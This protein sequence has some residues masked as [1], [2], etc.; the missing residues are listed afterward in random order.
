[1][2]TTIRWYAG[3]GSPEILPAASGGFNTLGFFGANFGFSIR[4]G[5]YNNSSFRTTADGSSNGGAL[6]NLR[7]AN[8]SGAYVAGELTATELKEIDNDEATLKIT[9]TTDSAIQTQN[10]VL[11]AFDRVDI[12]SNP[13]GVTILAAE[14]RND[15]TA[16]RGSGDTSWTSIA[17]SGST[18]GLEDQTTEDSTTHDFFIALTATPTSIGEK[19][20]VG[21]YWET[22]F[23]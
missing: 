23:L 5:E 19:T 10:S 1:M 11:R 3:D 2:A 8:S 17:G 21:F 16:G 20:S 15:I 14:I 7:W 12:N 6:P 13:S 18:L 9:L 4:V 22:E